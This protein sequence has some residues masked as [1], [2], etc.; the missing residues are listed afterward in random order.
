MS[1]I[2]DL[3]ALTVGIALLYLIIKYGKKIYTIVMTVIGVS[4]YSFIQLGLF[5]I[6]GLIWLYCVI[7]VL[8]EISQLLSYGFNSFNWIGLIVAL[9][10]FYLSTKKIKNTCLPTM[11]MIVNYIKR[12]MSRQTNNTNRKANSKTTKIYPNS[13]DI[14]DYKNG[15]VDSY[16]GYE[17][18]EYLVVLLK[19]LDFR[20]VKRVGGSGDRGVDI[21]AD[22][23]N[24]KYGFQAK[25]YDKNSFVGNKAV[26]EIYTGVTVRGLDRGIV[27]APANYSSDAVGTALQTN[28]EL[29]DR[30]TLSQHLTDI[31]SNI[32]YRDHSLTSKVGYK[33]EAA[34]QKKDVLSNEQIQALK[35]YLEILDFTCNGEISKQEVKSS[36]KTLAKRY[37]PDNAEGDERMFKL[38][39]T[40]YNEVM[41]S[42]I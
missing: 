22:R 40:A 12:P 19:A 8:N 1:V 31:Y 15:I 36:F 3:L 18:E 17:F 21:I 25:R 42:F 10:V 30:E 38:I 26:Q 20:N 4:V 33:E 16:T 14:L 32:E 28:V 23:S 39:K 13:P 7:Y 41:S 24:L 34:S 27:V 2:T 11:K 35:P 29:W 5:F 9:I 37:H 6:L